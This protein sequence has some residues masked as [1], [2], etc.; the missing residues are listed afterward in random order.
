MPK[1]SKQRI[2]G[3]KLFPYRKNPKGN[4]YLCRV[5]RAELP[6]RQSNFC[7]DKC[8]QHYR[9]VCWPSYARNKVYKRDN[10]VCAS[11]QLDTEQ[12]KR[13]VEARQYKINKERRLKG[14]LPVNFVSR[15]ESRWGFE[16]GVNYSYWENDHIVPVEHGGAVLGLDNMQTLCLRCHREKTKEQ[17]RKD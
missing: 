7:S 15:W 1:K 11:C 9:I 4:G 14:L 13:R 10:G 16:R 6:G 2:N 12:L 8:T 3:R 17:K 5:C